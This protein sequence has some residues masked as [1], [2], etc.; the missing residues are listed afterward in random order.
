MTE[1]MRIGTSWKITPISPF[2]YV[3]EVRRHWFPKSEWDYRGA[4]KQTLDAGSYLIFNQCLGYNKTAPHPEYIPTEAEWKARVENNI[5]MLY[6][7]GANR[8]NTMLTSINEGTKYF[9]IENG[10]GGVND[11]IKY[12][13]WMY[14]QV[15]GRFDIGIGNLEFY[16]AMVLGDWLRFMARDG[17]A[18]YLLVHIQNSCDTLEHTQQNLAY[19]KGLADMYGKKLSCSEA[20]HTGWDMSGSGYSK[21]LMQLIEAEKVGCQ[22][23]CIICTDLNTQAAKQEIDNVS[24][25]YPACFKIDGVKRTNNFDDL[26]RIADEKAPVPNVWE[27]IM[28]YLRPEQQ[29]IFYQAMGWGTKPYHENTPSLPIVGRKVANDKLSWA[30]FDAVFET[31]TKGLIEALKENNALPINFPEPMAIKYKPDGSYNNKWEEIAKSGGEE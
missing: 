17:K 5:Q 10:H 30:D 29:K 3:D 16:D 20:M 19:A 13:N 14:E 7:V 15:A 4:A 22:D 6:S 23:F 31:L 18:K 2:G 25:L 1:P 12:N 24:K 11:L 28:S 8:Y 27:V 26:V 21:L 9:R